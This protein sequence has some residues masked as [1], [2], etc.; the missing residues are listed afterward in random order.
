M[1]KAQPF[2]FARYRSACDRLPLI[3]AVAA[4]I[5]FAGCAVT[6][7]PQ[8]LSLSPQEKIEAEPQVALPPQDIWQRIRTGMQIIPAGGDRQADGQLA[9][10]VAKQLAWYKKNPRYL[11]TVF[12]RAE[13]FIFEVVEQLDR[14]G[15]PLEL[16]LLPVVESTYDPLAYSNSHAV[17][18]WQ[19]IPSTA[20][21]FG[22]QRSDNYEGRRDSV[23]ATAAAVKFLKY[24]NKQFDGQWLLALAAYNSGEGN[25]RRAVA[26]DIAKGGSGQFWDL[27]LPRETRNYVPQLLALSE[28]VM[29]PARHQVE[30]PNLP[31]RAF[32]TAITLSSPIDLSL[33][34]QVS[35]TEPELF[36]RLNAAFRRSVT[37]EGRA[38][39]L[40]PQENAPA[41]QAFLA[42]TEPREWAPY[43]EVTVR[44]GD[45]LSQLAER[46]NST[47]RAIRSANQLQSS[48]LKVGQ[49]LIIPP[50]GELH[51]N[52]RELPRGHRK[53]II[54]RGDS[55]WDIAKLYSTDIAQLRKLNQL[56]GSLL[57]PG[58]T[59]LVPSTIGGRKQAKSDKVR[60]RRVNYEVKNGDSL[61][62]IAAR[63][64]VKTAQIV[65][66]NQLNK[67]RYLQ[68]G[69]RLTIYVNPIEI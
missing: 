37:P 40:V 4:G 27:K 38:T 13:P 26:R 18:L 59:L 63:F 34:Q 6:E 45:T 30:L 8:P 14:A 35:A 60:L 49:T 29:D 54:Q 9:K 31:N 56:K 25:V 36:T 69:Q 48:R 15:L 17:G 16:A 43:R 53:H 22:L 62:R 23:A 39:L 19:F 46:H 11:E 1:F 41:L 3:L 44:W 21:A 61:S 7:Q 5:V 57:R 68:P 50:R 10:A 32:F 66:W 55:L 51:S 2:L 12:E 33:A 47:Q 24:L 20:K 42:S 65:S 67:S 52:I 64:A 58:D 28:L